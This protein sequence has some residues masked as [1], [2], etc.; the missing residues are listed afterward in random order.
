MH[1]KIMGTGRCVPDKVVD[2]DYLSTVMDTSDEWIS[3]RTGIRERRIATTE[4][5]VSMAAGAVRNALLSA[6]RAE[7]HRAEL[8][9]H[10]DISYAVLWLI[11]SSKK[12]E[13]H[14]K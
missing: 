2:N 13:N 1:G 3:S 7:E 5:T 6:G 9:S 12:T 8:R 10:G 14:G 11:K 4:S